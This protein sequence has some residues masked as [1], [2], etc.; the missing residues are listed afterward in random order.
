MRILAKTVSKRNSELDRG[1][2][3][4]INAVNSEDELQMSVA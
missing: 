2:V 1:L 4:Q 3:Q